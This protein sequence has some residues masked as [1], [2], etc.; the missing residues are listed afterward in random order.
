MNERADG[1]G[2]VEGERIAALVR[3]MGSAER[4]LQE[5]L[6]GEVDAVVDPVS[7]APLVLRHA[8]E[9]LRRSE[10]RMRLLLD[11]VPAVVWTT[12]LGL[13]LTSAGGRALGELGTQES[14]LVDRKLADLADEHEGLKSVLAAHERAMA[15][16]RRVACEAVLDGRAFEGCVE[17]AYGRSGQVS[18]CV[19][20]GLDVTERKRAQ[21]ALVEAEKLAVTGRMAASLAHEINNPLQAV[22]GCLSLALEDISEGKDAQR[23]V[24]VALEEL[25]RAASL[26]GRIRDLNRRPDRAARERAAVNALVERVLALTRKKC[27][28]RGVEVVWSPGPDL[29]RPAVQAN[30]LQ[31][32]FMN[33]VLNA[34]DAMPDGGSLYVSTARGGDPPGVRVRF[35]DT[36]VGIPAADLRRLFEP[37]FTTKAVGLGLGLS[38]SQEIVEEHEGRIEVESVEG[39]GTTFTVWLPA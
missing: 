17:P 20:V 6:A 24:Q 15:G 16:R 29:P 39:E 3:E 26:V 14:D 4:A 27:R 9:E 23:Y 31:Q 32:V 2:R 28:E 38:V 33:L 10:A 22:V 12:D 37:F 21:A 30:G 35:A 8:Q 36:G 5:L 18:G 11:Q 25:E 13:R 7:G 19:G 1:R 34:V